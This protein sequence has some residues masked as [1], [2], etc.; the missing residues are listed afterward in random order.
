MKELFMDP[1]RVLKAFGAVIVGVLAYCVLVAPL[2]K[3]GSYSDVVRDTLASVG[4]GYCAV[5]VVVG[6]LWLGVIAVINRRKQ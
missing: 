2:V 3:E 5:V 4:V 1:R 6:A